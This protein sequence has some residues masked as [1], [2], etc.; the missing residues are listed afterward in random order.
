[1]VAPR[2]F[3]KIL[4]L[5]SADQGPVRGGAGSDRGRAERDGVL[6]L[7]QQRGGGPDDAEVR[8]ADCVGVLP[9]CLVDLGG[10]VQLG[11]CDRELATSLGDAVTVSSTWAWVGS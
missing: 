3:R 5:T 8:G 1:M 9:Q 2:L 7:L 4:R 11:Q 6:A 10:R